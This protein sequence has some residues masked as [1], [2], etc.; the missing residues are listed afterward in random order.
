ML[1]RPRFRPHFHVEVVPEEGVFLLSD[2][3][4]TL[5][6]GRLYELVSPWLDGRK[7]DDVCHQLRGKASPAAVYYALAQLERKDYLCEQ[8]DALPASPPD[9]LSDEDL[10]ASPTAWWCGACVACAAC[11]RCGCGCRCG[12]CR[13]W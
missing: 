1:S 8:E 6:R 13:C 4:Q 12:A 11:G 9:E 3:K 5:L 7:A 10:I 2:S